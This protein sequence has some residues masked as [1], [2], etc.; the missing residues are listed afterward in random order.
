M[1]KVPKVASKTSKRY[2]YSS[3][4][5][6]IDNLRIEP[7]RDLSK[8]VH[9]HVET[10]HFLASFEH[11]EDINLSAGFSAF[12]DD[13]RPLVQTLPQILFHE[14]QI[15]NHLHDKISMHDENSLQPLLDLLSQFCHD[16]G[17]DF[18]K[19]YERAMRMLTSLLDAAIKF[20]SSNVF[21]W[22]FNCVAY[23]YKYLS[24]ILAQDL[25]P[26][27][28]LLFPILS[29]KKEYLSRFSAEVLSFLVRKTRQKSLEHFVH[30]TFEQLRAAEDESIYDGLRVLYTE[31]LIS[32]GESLHSKFELMMGTLIKAALHSEENSRCI[33][34]MADV[35][36]N[37]VRHASMENASQVYDITLAVIDAYLE[38]PSVKINP[39]VRLLTSLSFAESGRKTPSWS[40]VIACVNK[41][42]GHTSA[43]TIAS[44]DLA[45]LFCFILRNASLP[46][47]A[48]CHRLFFSIYLERFNDHF[49]S[50]F[51]LALKY[52]KDRVLSFG[53][54]KLLQ[55]FINM[56]WRSQSKKIALFFEELRGDQALLR[57]LGPSIPK[58]CVECLLSEI[59][60]SDVGQRGSLYELFWKL[61]LLKFG[62]SY[63]L[64]ALAPVVSSLLNKHSL[65]DFEKDVIGTTLQVVT[66]KN[67]DQLKNILNLA[68]FNVEKVQDSKLCVEGIHRTIDLLAAAN[69][70]LPIE[71]VQ[72]VLVTLSSNLSLPED[73]IRYETLKLIVKI[74][75]TQ[76]RDVPQVFNDCKL[77]EEIPRNLQTA[78]DVTMRLKA[79]GDEFARSE[80]DV[81]LCHVFLNYLFGSLTV[82]FSPAW[83]GVYQILPEI[84]EKD[85][86]LTWKLFLKF[87]DALDSNFELEYYTPDSEEGLFEEYGW[88]VSVTRLNDA[89]LGCKEIFRSY[90]LVDSS[91]IT[92]SKEA[93]SDLTYPG[94]IRNQALKGLL[95]IPQLAERHSRDIVPYFLKRDNTS[96]ELTEEDFENE[97]SA[98]S[99][100][101]EADRKLLLQL[102]GK[103]KN[104]KAIFKSDDV[105]TRL[106]DLLGSRTTEIQKMALDGILAY[107][108]KAV[109][110]YRDS[111]KNLLDDNAFKDE[112]LN[113]LSNDEKPLVDAHDEK[114]VMPIVLRILFGRAQTPVT[115]GLKK[116]RKTAVITLL[117][118]LAER[119]VVDFLKLTS[120]GLNYQPFFQNGHNV[121]ST[122]ISSLSLRRMT[123]FVT[124]GQAAVS[125]LGSRYPKA[126]TTL[127][128][129]VLYA[130]C[131]ANKVS[132]GRADKDYML[133]QATNVRQLSMKLVLSIFSTVG[134]LVDWTE[135]VP[136]IHKLMVE[137]RLLKFADENLQK[138][139]SL[140]TLISIWATNS[141]FYKFL[142]YHQ[143]SIADALME[144]LSR[145]NAKESVLA[146]V[147]N[148]SNQLIKNP[149]EESEYVD[150]VS[151]VASSCLK[152]LPNVLDVINSQETVTISLDLLLNLI[153]AGYVHDNE[154]K[155]YLINSL[156]CILERG[157][158]G[159][160]KSDAVKIMHSTSLLLEDY[161]CDWSDIESLY[162][163]CS[164]LYRTSGERELRISVNAVFQAMARIFK[165]LQRVA[166]LL[167]DLN[168]YSV[169]RM[170]TY[171]FET[172]LP[173][174]KRLD[175]GDCMLLNETEWIPVLNTCLYYIKNEE[176]L[177]L[178]TN[179]SH[180]LKRFVDYVN[181]KTSIDDARAAVKLIATDLLPE[182]KVGLRHKNVDVQA[183]YI[184]VIAY[185]VG[186][187]GYYS[188]LDDMKVLLYDGD[189]EANFFANINHIQLHRRQRAIKRLGESASTLAAD[190]I[191]HFLIPMIERY[192]YCT[193]ERYRNICNET[194]SAIGLLSH[195][196]TWSQYKAL[197]RRLISSLDSKPQFL[198]E[199]VSLVVHC[200]KALSSSMNAARTEGE[201]V[202]IK[203]LPTTLSDPDTFVKEEVFPKLLKILNTRDEETIVARIP[204]CEALV[205]LILGLDV[206][207]R[208]ILLPGVL[209]SVCQVLRSRSE[210]LREA[211][212]K[213]LASVSVILGHEYLTFILKELKSALRRGS[214]IHVLS[215]TIHS[216]LSAL[217]PKLGPGD[218]DATAR[219]IVEVIMEDT[220]GTAGQEKDAEGYTSKLKEIKFN[221]SYDTAEIIASNISL[222]AFG[223]LLHP[224]KALLTE[225][226]GL[227]N[228]RK[229]NELMRRYSL[230][231]NHN[232]ASSSTDAL[233][234]CY[235]IFTQ[236]T[237]QVKDAG[238]GRGRQKSNTFFLI[239]LSARNDKV[240]TENKSNSA[241]LRKFALDLLKTI[242]VKN[243]GLLE[244]AY[245]ENFIP[246]L[247]EALDS[248]EEEVLI[249]ALRVLI[250]LVKL[251][252]TEEHEGIFKNCAR[253]V[254]TVVRDSPSTSSDLCQ[255]SLKFLS[256][257][258]RHKDIEL[259]DTALSFI[260]GRIK[261]DLNEP[262]KQ[263]LAFNFV[264]SLV[265]K[266]IVLPELYDVVDAIAEIMITNHSKEIRDV[267]RSVYYQFL[268]EYD[269]SRGRLEKQ[270]K[271]LVSNLEY[272]SQEGRQSVMELINLIVNKSG[273]DLLLRISSS[274]FLSLSNVAANDT[275]PRC[276]EMGSTLLK[277]LLARLG[278]SNVGPLEK[279]ILAWLKHDDPTFVELGLKIYKIHMD[280]L[281]LGDGKG[282]DSFAISKAKKIISSGTAGSSVEW[283]L[284]YTALNVLD[285]YVE[286]EQDEIISEDIGMWSSTIDSLLY[287]HP[288][289]RLISGRMV[290]KY[291]QK[292]EESGVPLP[293]A[294]LQKIAY[295]IFHQL[296]A[297]SV[298][299]SLASTAVTI[300]V[301]IL[302]K[303]VADKTAF[304]SKENED[305][306]YETSIDFS[307][308]RLGSILRDE[309][310]FRET[311]VSKKASIQLFGFIVE[312]MNETELK[313]V[314]AA[315]I[316]PLFMYLE[317][318]RRIID[319]QV[320]E[321]QTMSQ[322]CIELLQNKLSVSDFSI[323]Y[324]RV[325]QEIARRRNERRARRAALAVT[326]PEAAARRKL[327]KHARSKEKRRHEKDDS[328]FYRAKN[329]K[330][331]I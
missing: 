176:E 276:R 184:S 314:A 291:I 300:L 279:Y 61:Q 125:A 119:Y 200:S 285:R 79:A 169:K 257:L 295:R 145:R 192:V 155:K 87:V 60:Q 182:V 112:C 268:M 118:S 217:S 299:E 247:Q 14:E 234:L 139:S 274:F 56:S 89:L 51:R 287:P 57:T 241:V 330:R 100:W 170:E 153:D 154:T 15:F 322:E 77:I 190:S 318:D 12:T 226:L 280:A 144:I 225:N 97:Q 47:L 21:E 267:S 11:W 207:A 66:F 317:D 131:V 95:L 35:I 76:G 18:M 132:S 130:I 222:T 277:N 282:L 39:T 27:F 122:E 10:S 91:I 156:A 136:K 70:A 33:S 42:V 250:I 189:Q 173:T 251:K 68:L 320:Q 319:E 259:K 255:V 142:Y 243:G 206:T 306:K 148:F 235:E 231:L 3:F 208:S 260:L 265:L 86:E 174:F 325:K 17:P 135:H 199:I 104:I 239:N 209:S 62:D 36:L 302:R 103:F 194:I 201:I 236:S 161:I 16:L 120:Q 269:Q 248:D 84:F 167:S 191:A 46:D 311:F 309:E 117:P 149:T 92:L 160:R 328:G 9:D 253:K 223:H 256:S 124:L 63:D 180:T 177:A 198:K 75:E 106:M 111:L 308:A 270:F 166:D 242:L 327:K 19:F 321:L 6:K 331:R 263:G 37:V 74:M 323:A 298:S 71:D 275:S 228:Q 113:L 301:V 5:D 55:R 185:I 30:H 102:I 134:E 324:S 121:D 32:K 204:L 219:M 237:T 138:P 108:D 304:I 171:D 24:R 264:K 65:D 172:V 13:V 48:Q 230:G 146:M 150:L 181:A 38:A 123:G 316:L 64:S 307:L 8:R 218:L 78:R 99:T 93:R 67:N 293:P 133:K 96:S 216:I 283:N 305:A 272:P 7:A 159:I 273:M 278:K 58:E 28:N 22:V 116:S 85:H 80:P 213:N 20:E 73:K 162:K 197:M 195:F 98:P 45:L 186:H 165:D 284:I 229:L 249:S 143:C 221:K 53:G 310:N 152:A 23:I 49:L 210:E 188:E 288:W 137:P 193:D 140:M 26:T 224:I 40:N 211:V 31:A 114:F 313:S 69:E 261:P 244:A 147:L 214:Q 196:V 54:A 227:K 262:N 107:K 90:S 212:R 240:Q 245:L 157:L 294:E 175:D 215:Y 50:F 2:R 254:L 83:E 44:E 52:D 109:I 129:P 296:G 1:V 94:L 252:F 115:S 233:V 178:R 281:A 187:S 127:M 183:E 232:V 128:D 105:Y 202:T 205:S 203:K 110:K 41:V 258:I 88:S 290:K 326:A 163:S 25:L 271:F 29:H 286:L 179:A 82:R 34:L 315:I 141:R 246:L 168:S 158:K 81:L 72:D 164:I 59:A 329:K 312:M 101:S 4:K 266:H 303:W 292:R 220:F 289:V 297:P 43:D 151:V 126:T 238:N